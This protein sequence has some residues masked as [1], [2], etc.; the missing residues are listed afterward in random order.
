MY[1]EWMQILPS[2]MVQ[3]RLAHGA[4]VCTIFEA[5]STMLQTFMNANTMW[6]IFSSIVDYFVLKFELHLIEWILIIFIIDVKITTPHVGRVLER[7][8][9]IT[10][11]TGNFERLL[12]TS[13]RFLKAT[14][15]T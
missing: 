1:T 8:C 7:R 10:I 3:S 15:K 4:Y 6:H 12:D 13:I 9:T 14:D 5:Q 11:Q 2:L